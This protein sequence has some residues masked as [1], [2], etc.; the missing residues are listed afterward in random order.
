MS[1]SPAYREE[2]KGGA[3]PAEKRPRSPV[4]AD[5]P[6]EDRRGRSRSSGSRHGGAR[7]ASSRSPNDRRGDPRDDGSA[8]NVIYIA[9]LS[10]STRE[11]DLKD[12][13]GRYGTIKSIALKHSFAFITFEKAESARE[14][15][16]KM[17]GAKFINDE[18]LVV[19]PSGTDIYKT[20]IIMCAGV[21]IHR[22]L[23][24]AW[25]KK[26]VQWTPKG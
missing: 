9:K 17:N 22:E 14:A 5:S 11:S 23:F 18:T 10:R 13:F 7:R 6:R 20:Y 12:A 26:E 1:D 21:Q 15:I 2:P 3:S 4:H 19:E 16:E 25:V 24:S 8:G